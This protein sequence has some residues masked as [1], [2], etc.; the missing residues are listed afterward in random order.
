MIIAHSIRNPAIVWMSSQTI[1]ATDAPLPEVRC[2]L[3]AYWSPGDAFPALLAGAMNGYSMREIWNLEMLRRTSAQSSLIGRI[4]QPKLFDRT[5]YLWAYSL[6]PSTLLDSVSACIND[7]SS[8]S[9]V[10]ACV[11]GVQK[12]LPPTLDP[13]LLTLY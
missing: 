5:G 6:T 8:Y 3:P 7:T 11:V 12:L 9:S 1:Q 2:S 4:V 13:L 10:P